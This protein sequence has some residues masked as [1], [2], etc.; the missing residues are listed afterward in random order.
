M[1]PITNLNVDLLRAALA[2]A[3]A[4]PDQW[5]QHA[6]ATRIDTATGTRETYSL[7]ARVCVHAGLAI[8]WDRV[9]A[10]GDATWLT[11]RRA[12]VDAANQLLGLDLFDAHALHDAAND[13]ARTRKIAERLIKRARARRRR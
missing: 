3:E 2:D 4:H 1:T 5:E 9:N 10:H 6:W 11:D 8:N 13:I 7:A 12:I